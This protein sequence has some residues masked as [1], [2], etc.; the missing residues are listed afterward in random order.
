MIDSRSCAICLW[1]YP[2]P[3]WT[4][5]HPVSGL[6]V[7]VCNDCTEGLNVREGSYEYPEVFCS[8][9]GAL[10]SYEWFTMAG[11][12]FPPMPDRDICSRCARNY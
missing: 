9:C 12:M 3:W 10:E 4:A 6:W 8:D 5:L 2:S 11:P 7:V 1:T